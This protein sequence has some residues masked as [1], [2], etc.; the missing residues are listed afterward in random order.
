MLGSFSWATRYC[1]R[2]R[3]QEAERR[4]RITRSPVH[5]SAQPNRWRTLSAR[6]LGRARSPAFRLAL[7]LGSVHPD[8]DIC[9]RD[10]RD[11]CRP[12]FGAADKSGYRHWGRGRAVADPRPLASG[13]RFH[14]C[15]RQT[16]PVG[17]SNGA[18]L[19]SCR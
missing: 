13:R 1:S 14:P 3:E 2:L 19:P 15:D 6:R 18:F 12:D 5:E 9:F 7:E 10:M 11:R 4:F 17:V 16:G 8:S